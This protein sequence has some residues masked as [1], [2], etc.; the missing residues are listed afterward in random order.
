METLRRIFNTLEDILKALEGLDPYIALGIIIFVIIG[1]SAIYISIRD[2]AKKAA[3][4]ARR[5]AEAAKKRAKKSYLWFQIIL[6]IIIVAFIALLFY[7]PN[8][9]G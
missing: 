1:M 2:R 5:R 8:L 4:E 6:G 7:Y 3:E 9:L